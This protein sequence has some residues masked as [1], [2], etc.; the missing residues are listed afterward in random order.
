[1]NGGGNWGK[2]SRALCSRAPRVEPLECSEKQVKK[3]KKAHVDLSLRRKGS[4]HFFAL[5]PK[6]SSC[7][8]AM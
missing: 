6:M 4:L 3:E 2:L 7:A 5:A 1:M 8:P